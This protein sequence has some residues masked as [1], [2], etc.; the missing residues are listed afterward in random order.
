MKKNLFIAAMSLLVLAGCSNDDEINNLVANN[1]NAITFDTYVGK[2][3]K[4]GETALPSNTSFGVFAYNTKDATWETSAS[5]ATPNFMFNQKVD[6]D[7]TTYTYSPMKYWPTADKISFIAY[8]P[9]N[10]NGVNTTYKNTSTGLPQIDFTAESAKVDFLVSGVANDLN[11]KTVALKFQ[12]ALSKIQ[13][14]GKDVV[15]GVTTTTITKVTITGVKKTATYDCA[16]GTWTTPTGDFSD[17]SSTNEYLFI[18]QSADGIKASIEYTCT[19]KDDAL[20]NPVVITGTAKDIDLSKEGAITWAA[21][22]I[23]A[24]SI[25]VKPTGVE[26]SATISEWGATE[27]VVAE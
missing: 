22:T 17:N 16:T 3:T 2:V 11:Q 8:H 27:P 21:N 26:F 12:H 5:T 10:E 24:Y 23:Y 25:A 13:F 7:G 20:A 15:S 14:T 1:K 6:F 4:A 19:T 9:Y 18:P